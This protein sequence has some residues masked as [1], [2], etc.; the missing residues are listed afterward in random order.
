MSST[1]HQRAWVDESLSGRV[2]GH[3]TYVLAAAIGPSAT[4]M[5]I[6]EQ[7]LALRL[8]G[9]VKLRWHN[10]DARRRTTIIR[11]VASCQLTYVAVVRTGAVNERPERQRR[12]CLERLWYE[13]ELV[14]ITDIVLESR[15][16]ADDDRDIELLNKLRGRHLVSTDIRIR[17]AVGRQEPILSI[18][19]AVCGALASSRAGDPQYQAMLANRL[20]VVEI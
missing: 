8:P 17:H 20:T 4:E 3:V 15:G 9:Q 2:G 10:E 13:L 12:K 5:D 14:G 11:T 16:Q 6:R 18:P 7:I 1:F 19:D